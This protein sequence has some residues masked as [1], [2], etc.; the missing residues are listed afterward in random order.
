V[1]R[2]YRQG[3]RFEWYRDGER[4]GDVAAREIVGGR[5]QGYRTSSYT[6]SPKPGAWR[7][8]LLTDAS[9]LIARS[10]FVVE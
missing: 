1:P 7:V 5:E 9:Q 8:D 3:I 10:H 6:S 2:R 4:A